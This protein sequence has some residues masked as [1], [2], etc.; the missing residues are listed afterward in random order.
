[1]LARRRAPSKGASFTVG[2]SAMKA[3]VVAGFIT[4]RAQVAIQTRVLPPLPDIRHLLAEA[5]DEKPKA[6]GLSNGKGPDL[7]RRQC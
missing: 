1:V 2:S 5:R 6:L 7:G 3:K 4:F